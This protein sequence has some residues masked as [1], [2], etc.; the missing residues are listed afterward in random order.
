VASTSY[1]AHLHQELDLVGRLRRE[2]E[3]ELEVTDIRSTPRGDAVMFVGRRLR[4]AESTYA[5]LR[6]RFRPLGYT[7]VLRRDGA[8]DV[9]VAQRGVV[10]LAASNPL[11]NVILLAATIVTT[12]MVGAGIAGESILPALRAAWATG[13]W[14][15][16]WPAL[17]AGAPFAGTLLFILGVH[18][19]GHYVAARLH[20]VHVTLPYFIPVPFGLGTF[21]AFIQMKSPVESRKALFD[22]GVAG[23]LAGLAVAVPLMVLGLMQSE[24][25][26][27]TNELGRLGSSVLLRWLA[28]IFVPHAA[29]EAV[30]LSPMAI[31]AWFG[32]LV[33]GF[34]LLPMGQLDGGH[35]AYA[36]LGKAA[37]PVALLTFAAM[38]VLG[39]TVWSGWFTWAIFA[40]ITGLRHPEPLNDVTGLDWG[41]TLVGLATLALLFVLITPRPF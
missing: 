7:A 37:R 33:T 21:G 23:P 32:L 6:E 17:V 20:G 18:E 36:V 39:Y 5:R 3:G 11:I 22:V 12:L 10:R 27:P 30:R 29:N 24:V 15:R 14:A 8:D 2:V 4:D 28:D 19:M 13:E 35:V 31:A 26:T 1:E 25:V 41:R 34:N 16:L 40:F 38:L 9:V